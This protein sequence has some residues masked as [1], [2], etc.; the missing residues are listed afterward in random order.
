VNLQGFPFLANA[1]DFDADDAISR[2]I[3]AY[4]SKQLPLP[5]GSQCNTT[6]LDTCWAHEQTK[7]NSTIRSKVTLSI[8]YEGL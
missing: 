2:L 5:L 6:L 4:S 3:H 1:I 8:N 7:T